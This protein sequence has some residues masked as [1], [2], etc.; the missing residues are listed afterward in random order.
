M[1][2]SAPGRL[3]NFP[4]FARVTSRR[5]GRASQ[6]WVGAALPPGMLSVGV[7]EQEARSAGR[8]VILPGC[9]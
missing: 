3:L 6:G 7:G 5:W 1:I 9:K 2:D 4:S 8:C